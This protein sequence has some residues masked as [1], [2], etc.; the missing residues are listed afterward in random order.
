M[1]NVQLLGRLTKTPELK[2]TQSGVEYTNFTLAVNRPK[3]DKDKD[4]ETDFISC[5]AFKKTAEIICNYF[6]K[7]QRILVDGSIHVS[8]YKDKEDKTIY[9]TKVV[10]N[11]IYFVESQKSNAKEDSKTV[12]TSNTTYQYEYTD[13]DEFPF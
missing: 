8:S 3:T 1:N 2:Q 7:G 6:D 9:Q 5:V 4:P 10:V 11:K 13:D 12:A